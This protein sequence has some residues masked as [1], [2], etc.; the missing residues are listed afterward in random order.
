MRSAT[1]HGRSC[2]HSHNGCL[3]RSTVQRPRYA[4]RL[5]SNHYP[6]SRRWS[7]SQPWDLQRRAGGRMEARYVLIAFILYRGLIILQITDAVHAGGCFIY[8]QLH[9]LGR[10]ADPVEL[11]KLGYPY[12]SASDVKHPDQPCPPR[13]LTVSGACPRALASSASAFLD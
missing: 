6:S 2:A 9:A 13:P 11:G 12:V 7:A 5:R 4:P 3:L 8:L 10:V 1:R